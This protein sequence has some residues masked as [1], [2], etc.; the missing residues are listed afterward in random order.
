MFENIAADKDVGRL[1]KTVK[2]Q[3][4]WSTNGPPISLLVD[5]RV[6]SSSQE[7]ASTL[8]DYYRKKIEDL[9]TALPRVRKDP[10]SWLKNQIKTFGD[11][12][13]RRKK[14][15]FR[16]I[17]LS[18]T[19]K[20]IDSLGTISAFGHDELDSQTIKSIAS[21]IYIPIHHLI[22]ISLRTRK[23]A[24]R[25]KIGRL[26]P[27][28]KGKKLDRL[29]T[30]S[31]RPVSLLPLVSKLVERVVQQQMLNFLNETQQLN[32]YNNAY[33]KG[34]STATA[35][36]QISDVIHSAAELNTVVNVMTV[37]ETAAFDCICS[38]TLDSKLKLYNFGTET[39]EWFAD[40]LGFRSQ[41]V[42]I[43]SKRSAMMQVKYGVP[44]GSVLGPL[45]YTLYINE[46]PSILSDDEACK[47]DFHVKQLRNKPET[48]FPT[49]CPSC[50]NIPSFADDEVDSGQVD[51]RQVDSGTV[52][53]WTVGKWTVGKWTVGKWTVGKWTVGQWASGQW[54]SGQW[55]SGQWASGQWASGQWA[56][57]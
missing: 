9:M 19:V 31:Y 42:S 25:W 57:G 8:L 40:Y 47:D 53:K 28:F 46:L 43:G 24:N 1:Y 4:G 32:P 29:Q 15:E 50:P 30:S 7:M 52:G 49:I 16:Q 45:L 37:D 34:F 56:S 18:E 14:F 44:Q 12:P 33:R 41:Y 39:R 11:Y 22:N 35:L 20:I 38:K 13:A 27:L 5:D 26:I 2:T 17:S 36:M 3:L 51:S 48:L 10:T 23:F 55:A 54:A 6:T 21:S